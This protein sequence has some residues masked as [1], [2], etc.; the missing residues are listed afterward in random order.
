[1]LTYI[2]RRLLISLVTIW[3]ISLLVFVVIEL[4]PGDAITTSMALVGGGE[5]GTSFILT[6]EEMDNLR[7]LYALDKPLLVRYL[8]WLQ[9]LAV[10]RLGVSYAYGGYAHPTP[11]W[12]VVDD[13]FL[14]TIVVTGAATLIT[15]MLIIPIGIFSAVRQYSLGDYAASFFGFIG[16]ATPDF[17]LALILLFLVF[18]YAGVV[19]AGLFSPAYIDAA[20]SLGKA[21]D[22][23]K[24]LWVPGIVLGTS[25][26]AAG[27]RILRANLLDEIR[28]PYVL[29]A[30]TRGLSEIRLLMKYPLRVAL[31][32]VVSSIGYVLPAMIGGSVIVS[33]VLDL[34][35]VGPVLLEALRGQDTQLAAFVMLLIGGLTVVGTL[36]SDILLAWLDPRIRKGFTE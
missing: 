7:K 10:G 34:N 9:R 36:V 3:G 15:W 20:W 22:L 18:K 21:W 5:S 31:N 27:I 2:G 32:P 8:N 11:V 4:P 17:L 26:T 23:L 30:R 29:T 13:K 28:R 12:D 25:G 35:T 19:V 33:V 1:M 14:L 24:H 6:D 16:M